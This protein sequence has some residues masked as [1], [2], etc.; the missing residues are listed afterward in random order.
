[1]DGMK[2]A[3]HYCSANFGPYRHD[4]LRIAEVPQYLSSVGS[5]PTLI[6]FSEG[7]EFIF[8][9]GNP[10][11]DLDVSYYFTIQEVAKQWWGQH[12]MP[13]T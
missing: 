1:M 5:F 9:V 4:N 7:R 6:P 10:G 11:K 2:A 12:L 3:F 8:R 13:A